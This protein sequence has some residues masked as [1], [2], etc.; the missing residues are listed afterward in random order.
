ML[1]GNRR[2]IWTVSARLAGV[3]IDWFSFGVDLTA[4][5]CGWFYKVDGIVR[6]NDRMNAKT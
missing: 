2:G 4:G 3:K 1:I 6:D 5:A